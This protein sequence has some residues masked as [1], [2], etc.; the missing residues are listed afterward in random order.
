[1]LRIVVLYFIVPLLNKI[2]TYDMEKAIKCLEDFNSFLFN[3]C[4]L[5]DMTQ[6]LEQFLFGMPNVRHF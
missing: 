3:D 6:L 2:P 1:M 4:H 5:N